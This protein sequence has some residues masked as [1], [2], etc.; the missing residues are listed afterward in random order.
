MLLWFVF[1]E[2]R[3]YLS[4]CVWLVCVCATV[5]KVERDSRLTRH[6]LEN[7]CDVGVGMTYGHFPGDLS[8]FVA[9]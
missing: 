6:R 1:F 4:E 5:M 9:L 8:G 7:E 3:S 2:N